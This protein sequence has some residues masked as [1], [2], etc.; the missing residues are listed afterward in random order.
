MISRLTVGYTH[1]PCYAGAYEPSIY[2]YRITLNV[3]ASIENDRF[4]I[5]GESHTEGDEWTRPVT[6]MMA[7]AHV[8]NAYI[9][10]SCPFFIKVPAEDSCL[11]R[12]EFSAPNI[13]VDTFRDQTRAYHPAGHLAYMRRKPTDS[14]SINDMRFFEGSGSEAINPPPWVRNLP[15]SGFRYRETRSYGAS[16]VILKLDHGGS[17]GAWIYDDRLVQIFYKQLEDIW[18]AL[19]EDNPYGELFSKSSDEQIA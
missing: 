13:I 11:V 5:S 17:T 6:G 8:Q 2:S 3:G 14:N 10:F 9:D 18:H 1:T 7:V 16:Y 4:S 15:E 19:P 12:L